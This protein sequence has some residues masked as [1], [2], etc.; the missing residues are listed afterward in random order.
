MKDSSAGSLFGLVSVVGFSG[1]CEAVAVEVAAMVEGLD[2]YRK[3]ESSGGER[4]KV[5]CGELRN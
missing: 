1:C 2:E 4:N 3:R 5:I